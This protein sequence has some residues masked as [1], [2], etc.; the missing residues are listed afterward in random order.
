MRRFWLIY[1]HKNRLEPHQAM[2]FD[3]HEEMQEWYDERK[4]DIKVI[5]VAKSL[6]DEE[7]E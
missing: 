6:E 7:D 2:G 5:D 1:T 4:E 3:D